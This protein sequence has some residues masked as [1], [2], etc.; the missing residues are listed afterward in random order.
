[1][2]CSLFGGEPVQDGPRVV[3]LPTGG[4]REWRHRQAARQQLWD[5][6]CHLSEGAIA[7][8]MGVTESRVRAWRDG[9]V[10][11]WGPCAGPH[12]VER[13]QVLARLGGVT[14]QVERGE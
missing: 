12:Q 13:L 9:V 10:G 6:V 7:Q 8:E 14:L 2:Q 4:L 5:A 3:V 11:R 1:M